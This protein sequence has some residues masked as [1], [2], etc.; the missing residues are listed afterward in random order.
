V[1]PTGHFAW[2][3]FF[4]IW[5]LSASVAKFLV[6]RTLD[7][8]VSVAIDAVALAIPYVPSAVVSTAFEYTA[9]LVGEA[10]QSVM[11]KLTDDIVEDTKI[12]IDAIKDVVDKVGSSID[13]M[14][15][16]NKAGKSSGKSISSRPDRI[17]VNPKDPWSYLRRALQTGGYKNVPNKL[18]V[19]WIDGSYQYFVRVHAGDPRYT[20]E[21]L[22]FRVSRKSTMRDAHNQGTGL[23]Y[24]GTD[25]N[26]YHESLL[27]EFHKGGTRNPNFNEEWARITHIPVKGGG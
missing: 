12:V 14:V 5:S 21:P 10:Y 8:L 25:G 26:W 9:K 17:V 23:E 22:I 20:D 3:T 7:N 6:N 27:K 16:T 24:L 13:E 19:R 15:E 2:D 4:D 18:D 11:L 1:D